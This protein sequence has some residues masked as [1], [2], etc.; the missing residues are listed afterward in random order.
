EIPPD[1]RVTCELK[2]SLV[3]HVSP[4][5]HGR[6]DTDAHVGEYCLGE[7]EATETQ[8][9]GDQHNVHNIGHQMPQYD[10]E[11]GDAKCIRGLDILDFTQLEYLCPQEPTELRPGRDSHNNAEIDQTLIGRKRS[12]LGRQTDL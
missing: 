5:L 1:D 7:N 11:A 4:R 8:D 2:S 6:I 12:V 10:G 9:D 3:D